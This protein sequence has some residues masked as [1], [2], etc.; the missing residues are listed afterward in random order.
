[1]PVVLPR[2]LVRMMRPLTDAHPSRRPGRP[3]T[4]AAAA[5]L[6]ATGVLVLAGCGWPGGSSSAA[7]GS[8]AS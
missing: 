5:V 2:A 7:A 3:R 1:M 6:A 4:L 8:A